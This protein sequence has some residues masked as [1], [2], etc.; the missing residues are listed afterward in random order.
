MTLQGDVDP[1]L[2]ILID[3]FVARG[4]GEKIYSEVC[5]IVKATIIGGRYPTMYSPSGMWDEEAYYTLANDFIVEKLWK[6]GYLGYLLQVN[7]SFRGFR[8]G[9]ESTFK[10]FLIS[11]R[12]KTALDNL[13]RR[14]NNIL[15]QD[16][17]FKCFVNAS[18]KAHSL[19]GLS[20]WNMSEVFNGREEDLVRTGLKLG[21][22]RGTEY[23]PEAKKISHIL[24]DKELADFM[25]N[26]FVEINSSL[27]L[28]QLTIVFKYRFNLLEITEVSLEEPISED[29]EGHILTIGDT[30]SAPES[31]TA[32]LEIDEAVGKALRL[33]SPR[34]KYILMEFQDREATLSSIGKRVGC[35]KST[36]ANEL[37]RIRSIIAEVSDDNEQASAIYNKMVEVIFNEN[38]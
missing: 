35:S 4:I 22:T 36:V 1:S 2:Q 33:L 15:H 10:N 34:Q 17:R 20:T 25:Y 12:K 24:S 27:S 6:R 29:G 13:F 19:W 5:A 11:K 7:T 26:L 14:A 9:V 32:A 8:K 3:E 38:N 18:K 16:D 37:Q 21:G 28:S 23:R 30:L 31:S